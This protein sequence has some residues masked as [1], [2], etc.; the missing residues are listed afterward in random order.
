MRRQGMQRDSFTC[1]ELSQCSQPFFRG[2]TPE[3]ILHVPMKPTSENVFRPE[4]VG[5][6][7]RKPINW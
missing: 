3:M 6:W 7:E 5:S 1:D 4:K 2:E